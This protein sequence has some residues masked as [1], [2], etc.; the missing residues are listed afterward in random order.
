MHI[1]ANTRLNDNKNPQ[2][3]ANKCQLLYHNMNI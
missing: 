2:I 1:K 3:Q